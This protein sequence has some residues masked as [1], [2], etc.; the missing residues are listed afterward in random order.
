MSCSNPSIAV[1]SRSQSELL[2]KDQ[3]TTLVETAGGDIHYVE[4]KISHGLDMINEAE[5]VNNN[6]TNGIKGENGVGRTSSLQRKPSLKKKVRTKSE[7]NLALQLVDDQMCLTQQL[8]LLGEPRYVYLD[9]KWTRF[10]FRLQVC[11][12]EHYTL[13]HVHVLLYIYAE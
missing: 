4:K 3:G 7:G 5:P 8:P 11:I 6:V 12:Y 2:N 9:M 10:G 13:M 1:L